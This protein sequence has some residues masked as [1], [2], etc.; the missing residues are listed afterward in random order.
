LWG[1]TETRSLALHITNPENGVARSSWADSTSRSLEAQL[2]DAARS[3]VQHAWVKQAKVDGAR[4]QQELERKKEDARADA[5]RSRQRM[6][7]LEERLKAWRKA[8]DIRALLTAASKREVTTTTH[9]SS[10]RAWARQHAEAL[11]AWAV[12]TSQ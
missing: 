7:D 2:Q 9:G 10:W 4:H 5:E 6:Q 8:E 11:T 12:R 1:S 3:I